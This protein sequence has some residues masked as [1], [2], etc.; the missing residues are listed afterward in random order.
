M[1]ILVGFP[2]EYLSEFSFRIQ[3]K[4][5]NCI[6]LRIISLFRRSGIICF[7]FYFVSLSDVFVFA[8]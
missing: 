2:D 3:S 1:S 8:C 4:K 6:Y 5:N 7:Y